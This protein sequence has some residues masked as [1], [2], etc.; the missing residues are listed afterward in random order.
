MTKYKTRISNNLTL[1]SGGD[2]SFT[3]RYLEELN[4]LAYQN[5][6]FS[7]LDKVKSKQTNKKRFMKSKMNL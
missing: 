2:N 4:G 6:T 1:P 5:L 7:K 3:N